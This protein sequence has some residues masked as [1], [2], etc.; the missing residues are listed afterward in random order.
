MYLP[1]R[2]I[3]ELLWIFITKVPLI[4]KSSLDHIMSQQ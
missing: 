2:E 4:P 1:K 3:E